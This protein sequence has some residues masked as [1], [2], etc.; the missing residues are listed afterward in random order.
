MLEFCHSEQG[1][2]DQL[3]SAIL[4]GDLGVEG[5]SVAFRRKDVFPLPL[6]FFDVECRLGRAI[7]LQGPGLDLDARPAASPVL[8]E[9]KELHAAREAGVRDRT[10]ARNRAKAL[11]GAAP[12]GGV[13]P[14]RGER[15]FEPGA[16]PA[17]SYGLCAKRSEMR[18]PAAIAIF[19]IT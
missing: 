15:F 2:G 14:Q 7:F 9:L 16:A 17:R 3:G 18:V 1:P 5:G 6:G 12:E 13:G 8:A 19:I 11:H 10:A 4:F